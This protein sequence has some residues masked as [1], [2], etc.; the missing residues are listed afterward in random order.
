MPQHL[1]PRAAELMSRL[2]AP[3]PGEWWL[4]DNDVVT[5]S[6]A[7]KQR[8]DDAEY[9]WVVVNP[10]MLLLVWASPRTR[11]DTY[12]G[13]PHDPHPVD[14]EPDCQIDCPGNVTE[15][16]ELEQSVFREATYSC[17]EPDETWPDLQAACKVPVPRRPENRRRRK[18]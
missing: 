11:Q 18:P 12:E 13:H 5:V 9:R 2:G 15:P 16:R 1:P 4:I 14:H 17:V 7:K 10:P 8:G 6:K 3:E